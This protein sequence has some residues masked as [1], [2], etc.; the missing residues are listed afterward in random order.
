[1]QSPL[2][3]A[4]LASSRSVCSVP[5]TL[6]KPATARDR[7]RP[8]CI[9]QAGKW[10]WGPLEWAKASDEKDKDEAYRIQ[11]E[12]LKRRRNNSWE[13]SVQARRADVRKYNTDKEY[14]EK[15][16]ADKRARAQ[17]EKD[18]RAEATKGGI[19]FPMASFGIPEYDLGERF[20]LKGPYVDSGWV[21]EDADFF[22]QIGKLFGRKSKKPEGDSPGNDRLPPLATA[23]HLRSPPDSR[24]HPIC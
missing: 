23:I 9:P 16:N 3:T 18:A 12:V 6:R 11:Q 24:T 8:L 10:S 1:M 19:P 20:D 4:R 2:S 22:K 21:D 5:F 17:K 7:S 14:R 13:A 15:V